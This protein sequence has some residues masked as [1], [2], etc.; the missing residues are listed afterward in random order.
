MRVRTL[1]STYRVK[2]SAW[3]VHSVYCGRVETYTLQRQSPVALG[4][5]DTIAVSLLVLV[6]VGM[7]DFPAFSISHSPNNNK[8][9]T[10]WTWPWRRREGS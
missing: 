1:A 7:A 6:V 9:R 10:S 4:L 5:L 3:L 8:Q 2:V